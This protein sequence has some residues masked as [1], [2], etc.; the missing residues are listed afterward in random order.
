MS[1]LLFGVKPFDPVTY[2]SMAALLIA[3]ASAASYFPARAGGQV[4]P[5]R[6]SAERVNPHANAEN[7]RNQGVAQHLNHTVICRGQSI[8]SDLHIEIGRAG[9]I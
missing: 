3:A 7:A 9:G 6:D 1:S 5:D 2:G 8:L 4:G